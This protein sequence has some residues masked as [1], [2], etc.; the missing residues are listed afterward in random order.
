MTHDCPCSCSLVVE[1]YGVLSDVPLSLRGPTIHRL[2]LYFG[3]RLT[4]VLSLKIL[5]SVFAQS[6]QTN[7]VHLI[8]TETP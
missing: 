5:S 7:T 8:K 2:G 6:I 1:E 4:W 3:S